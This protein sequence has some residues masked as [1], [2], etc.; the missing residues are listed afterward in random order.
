M[1]LRIISSILQENETSGS[2]T[3]IGYFGRSLTGHK[4]F[5]EYDNLSLIHIELSGYNEE[6]LKNYNQKYE[7][8]NSLKIVIDV[9]KAEWPKNSLAMKEDEVDPTLKKRAE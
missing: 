6:S 8:L 3:N 7:M 4:S 1:S 9:N 5:C 2:L